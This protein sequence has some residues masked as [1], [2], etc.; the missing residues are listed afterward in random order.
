LLLRDDAHVNRIA[1][2]HPVAVAIDHL[3]IADC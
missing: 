1:T 2:I 3:R